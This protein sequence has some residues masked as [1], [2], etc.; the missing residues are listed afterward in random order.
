MIWKKNTLLLFQFPALLKGLF[1]LRR[2]ICCWL[3]AG[4][5]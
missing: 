2:L 4:E 5:V 3:P 1:L